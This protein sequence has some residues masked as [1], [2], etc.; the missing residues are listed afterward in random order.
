SSAPASSPTTAPTSQ[1]WNPL[2]QQATPNCKNPRGVVWY[3]HSGGTSLSCTGAGLVMRQKSRY[4]AEVDLAEVNGSTY[5]QTLFRVEVRNNVLRSFINGQL[6]VSYS[7]SL[8]PKPGQVGLLVEGSATAATS[9][10]LFS[11]FQLDV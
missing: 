3:V 4:Y 1:V 10:I 2:L 11:N 9:S 5:N 6:V 8:N 7:D